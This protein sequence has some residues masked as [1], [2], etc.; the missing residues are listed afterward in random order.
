MT[1]ALFTTLVATLAQSTAPLVPG[2]GSPWFQPVPQHRRMVFQPLKGAQAQS[3]LVP[4]C[5]MRIL[6][7]PKDVDP[8]IV[9]EP[10]KNARHSIRIIEPSCR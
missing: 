1:L 10:P 3:L 5:T 4:N 8:K 2:F 9:V 6:V 7:A